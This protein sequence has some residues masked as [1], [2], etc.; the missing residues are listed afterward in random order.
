MIKVKPEYSLLFHHQGHIFKLNLG[1]L[2]LGGV[3]STSIK[4]YSNFDS[5]T[6]DISSSLLKRKLGKSERRLSPEQNRRNI[7][8]KQRVTNP[9][10]FQSSIQESQIN[11]ANTS[12]MMMKRKQKQDKLRNLMKKTRDIGFLDKSK[13]SIESTQD[14]YFRTAH[15]QTFIQKS[16]NPFNISINGG[17]SNGMN[18]SLTNLESARNT[19]TSLSL[20]QK[21]TGMSKFTESCNQDLSMMINNFDNFTQRA[22]LRASVIQ[23]QSINGSMKEL[24]SQDILHIDTQSM[25][26]SANKEMKTLLFTLNKVIKNGEE[27]HKLINENHNTDIDIF[28]GIIYNL[29]INLSD[30]NPPGVLHI[31]YT[32]IQKD[33]LIY[34]SRSCKE[35]NEDNNQGKYSN[36]NKIVFN[37]IKHGNTTFFKERFLYLTM[38]SSKGS[39]IRLNLN[40][41]Q[42]IMKQVPPQTQAPLASNVVV[43][44]NNPDGTL[45]NNDPNVTQVHELEQ[46]SL[47]VGSQKQKK[48]ALERQLK[49]FMSDDKSFQEFKYRINELKKN[50]QLKLK[51]HI[52]NRKLS[53]NGSPHNGENIIDRNCNLV[54][55]Y[56][57]YESEKR[58]LMGELTSQQISKAKQLRD[59]FELQAREKNLFLINRWEH[60]RAQAQQEKQREDELRKMVD[61]IIFWNKHVKADIMVRKIAKQIFEK[62]EE[63]IKRIRINFKAKRFQNKCKAY[64]QRK[65]TTRV[66]RNSNTIRYALSN[67]NQLINPNIEQQ[68]KTTFLD[69]LRVYS[70][71][72][73]IKVKIKQFFEKLISIQKRFSNYVFQMHQRFEVLQKYYAQELSKMILQIVKIKQKTK[74]QKDLLQKLREITDSM[75]DRVLAKYLDKC[76]HENAIRFFDWRKKVMNKQL[77]KEQQFAMSLR[78]GRIKR[79]DTLLFQNTEEVLQ[80]ELKKL[81]ENNI[82]GRGSKEGQRSKKDLQQ[83]PSNQTFL[84]ENGEET[85]DQLVSDAPLTFQYVPVL[86]VMRQLIIK[87]TQVKNIQEF[88]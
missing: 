11:R 70:K 12:N 25:I 60:Y 74:K 56:K 9:E 5:S 37:G 28:E 6:A 16:K 78:M 58:K 14:E 50:R 84:T 19:K 17:G 82:D 54:P 41:K 77:D 39:S 71:K 21:N 26:K 72:F 38:Q 86:Q 61:L 59:Q 45:G 68:A 81:E 66:L 44:P 63:K 83:K 51:S 27:Q 69:F 18:E 76:K 42:E 46:F 73:F 43:D 87:A 33:L 4:Y 62:R 30:K 88:E 48:Q 29:K 13:N 35:P 31:T 20:K 22:K 75:R 32:N 55:H 24:K 52:T 85:L 47:G 15:N 64:F 57:Q 53:P 1:I 2:K 8:S 65:G 40:F 10:L 34:I 36:P 49:A 7:L 79:S 23:A 3:D 80:K 67:I